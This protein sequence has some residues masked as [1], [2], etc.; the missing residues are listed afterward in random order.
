M[1]LTTTAPT[2]FK[3]RFSLLALDLLDGSLIDFLESSSR[4]LEVVD[5]GLAGAE[6][7][8]V[9]AAMIAA[10]SSLVGLVER[11]STTATGEGDIKFRLVFEIDGV[12]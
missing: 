8:A 11:L 1:H 2:S 10:R 3:R 4:P 7:A 9:A 12:R 6:S 5:T